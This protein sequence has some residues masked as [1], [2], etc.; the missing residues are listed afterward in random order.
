MHGNA[1]E[2][3][4]DRYGPYPTGPVTD[5][6]GPASGDTRVLRGGGWRALAMHCRA[7]NRRVNAPDYR[8]SVLGFRVARDAP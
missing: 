2:W 5:P 3:V 7:A 8:M 4:W 6:T 1:T